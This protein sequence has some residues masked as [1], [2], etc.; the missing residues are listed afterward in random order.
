MNTETQTV[1]GPQEPARGF[2]DRF[3]TFHLADEEYGIEITKVQEIIG[4]LPI[5]KVPTAPV[6]CRG[7]INLRGK[8]IPTMDLRLKL[9]FQAKEDT[10][11]T[12]IIIVEVQGQNGQS[13]F[14]LVVDEVAEVLDIS[15]GN[16][17]P[18][19]EY[20]ESLDVTLIQG[21]GVVSGKVKILLDFD[22]ALSGENL[23]VSDA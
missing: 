21:I 2:I 19:P 23:P 15:D 14:G 5:T 10:S 1:S 20:G 13:L 6:Y 17:N 22:R 18:P 12:C 8:V 9:G 7:V 11:R 16:I 4:L 3:F